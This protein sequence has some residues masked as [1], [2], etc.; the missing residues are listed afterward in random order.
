MV[1]IYDIASANMEL[2]LKEEKRL[3]YKLYFRG[4]KLSMLNIC[5]FVQL[6][7]IRRKCNVNQRDY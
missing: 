6:L 7:F 3:N 2:T 1:H 4:P 5:N